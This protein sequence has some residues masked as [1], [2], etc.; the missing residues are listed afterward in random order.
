MNIPTYNKKFA[1]SQWRRSFDGNRDQFRYL[2]FPSREN[3]NSFRVFTG[4]CKS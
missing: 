3:A 4:R 2:R 1:R